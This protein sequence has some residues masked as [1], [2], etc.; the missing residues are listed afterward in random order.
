MCYVT[1]TS[2]NTSSTEEDFTP[3]SQGLPQESA[4]SLAATWESGNGAPIQGNA[5]TSVVLGKSTDLDL[6]YVPTG[7][8]VLGSGSSTAE[9][10]ADVLNSSN[11]TVSLY[12]GV[13]GSSTLIYSQSDLGGIS[14]TSSL[15]IPLTFSSEGS[16]ILA[17]TATDEE[18]GY[19]LADFENV[20][21]NGFAENEAGTMGNFI[22]AAYGLLPFTVA[23]A[24][25]TSTSSAASNVLFIPGTLT[26]R[27]YMRN[28][29]GS[30]RDLWEPRSDLDVSPLA[31]NPDGTSVNAIYT[32]DVIDQLYSNNSLY[33]TLAQAVGT[34]MDVYGS[35]NTFMNSLVTK[36]TIKEW[37]A[38]PYDW[39]YDAR[40]IVTNG[41]LVGTATTAPTTVYIQDV[42]Q[43]LAST[44]PTGKVT[45]IAH[46]DGGLIAKAL[47]ID[48][49]KKGK[50]GLLDRIILVG[51]PQFGTPKAITDLLHGDEFTQALGLIMYSDTV[52]STEA[53]MP[54]P[55]DLL[56]SP[57][58]F[59]H[60]N[61]P[62]VAF[63][64][65]D[66]AKEFHDTIGAVITYFSQLSDF[67]VDAFNLDTSA[68]LPGST[69]TPIPLSKTLVEKSEATHVALDSWVPPAGLAITT[70]SGVGNL[71]P[72]EESYTGKEGFNCDR[73]SFFVL[74][75]CSLLPQLEPSEVGNL[76]GD[77]TVVAESAAGESGNVFYVDLGAL[78][79]NTGE[80]VGHS[81]LLSAS[82]VQ[83]FIT[84]T[85]TG[86]STS[87]AYIS[88]TTPA[89][90]AGALVVISAHS[91]VNLLATDADGDQT[92]VIPLGT[93]PGIY[94]Q[95]EEI[96]GSSV[97]VIGE[98]KYLYL[99]IGQTYN[100][101]MQGYDTGT[102]TIDVDMSDSASRTFTQL[103]EFKDIPTTASTT[104]NFTVAADGATKPENSILSADALTQ[105]TSGNSLMSTT[106]RNFGAASF[107]G[108]SKTQKTATSAT[109]S[110]TFFHFS[111]Q[112][113]QP[114]TSIPEDIEA[115]ISIISTK[116]AW[117]MYTTIM[118]T[119]LPKF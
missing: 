43:E 39:R 84:D 8:G 27:L 2:E 79:K 102:T 78:Q 32:R 15:Q 22:P 30:E 16:Y 72:L 29:D 118:L 103:D 4:L 49:A 109:S 56:P 14:A 80:I 51:T 94:F 95:K 25:T 100:V 58:Y 88:S 107:G 111:E 57:A 26:S 74:L 34:N 87:S 96:P 98:E 105:D 37:R 101:S 52:R 76:D 44:S 73:T 62:V 65:I 60:I 3:I 69:S 112:T 106:S 47:A 68:G 24:S 46:S 110:N 104:E 38:Y 33:H 61:I 19:S 54:G 108:S 99:P 1:T 28:P 18:K 91:P 6:Q 21:T 85:L 93:L 66:P 11:L 63:D 86:S 75:A 113:V 92:G 114:H 17:F 89:N 70:I 71:T 42:V 7:A 41:T 35:F 83:K 115:F 77:D 119:L 48:L 81:S 59:T 5:T 64:M 13:I 50:L 45:I 9:S 53:T 55:Y 82:A 67:L 97:Q 36:G 90:I 23:A 116:N 20:M 12:K 31:M 10:L 117:T 40:D